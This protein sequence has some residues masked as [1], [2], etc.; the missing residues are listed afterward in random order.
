MGEGMKHCRHY[1]K[2]LDT[3]REYI[4]CLY[5]LDGCGTGGLLHI[6]LDDGNLED[7]HIQWCLEQCEANPDQEEAEI[8]K[9]ICKELLKLPMQQRRLVYEHDYK[10]VLRCL[11]PSGCK[12]CWIEDGEDI[13][14]GWD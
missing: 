14:E 9:L 13:V 3:I 4:S 1:N 12:E 8:G 10:I 11:G 5:H 6:V 2:H 7:N